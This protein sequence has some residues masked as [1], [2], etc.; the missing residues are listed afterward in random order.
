MEADEFNYFFDHGEFMPESM[1]QA[2][3]VKHDDTIE[4]PARHISMTDGYAEEAGGEKKAT[5]EDP[6]K[7]G[8]LRDFLRGK[9]DE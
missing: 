8:T 9:K 6:N 7:T 1:K 3:N 2:K 4:R 5:E